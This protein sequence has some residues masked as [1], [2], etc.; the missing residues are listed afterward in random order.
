MKPGYRHSPEA[1]QRIA[2]ATRTAMAD[3]AVREKISERTK[4]GMG[5]LPELRRLRDAWQLARPSVRKAFIEEILAPL[6]TEPER[7]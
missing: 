2:E 7:Q 3:P 5:T 6:F 1:R 4:I